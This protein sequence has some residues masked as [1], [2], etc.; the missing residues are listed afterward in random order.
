MFSSLYRTATLANHLIMNITYSGSIVF[1][2]HVVVKATIN[3]TFA[4]GDIRVELISPSQ[5]LSVLMDYRDFDSFSGF[6]FDWPFMSV[7]YWGENPS[8]VWTLVVRFRGFGSA[9]VSR[10][11]VIFYG[12]NEVPEAVQGIPTQCDPACERGCAGVGSE[13]C[14]AC[15]NLR[16]AETLECIDQC[17]LGY[18]ERSGYCYNGSA[19]EPVCDRNI[20]G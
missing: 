3:S 4:R 20:T 19:P 11:N 2:E 15:V 1:I 5:T 8:G 6:F 16:D 9:D 13:Y 14:D 7:H 17:P 12:T 10:L 18:V